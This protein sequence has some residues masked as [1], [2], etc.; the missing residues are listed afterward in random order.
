M[1]QLTLEKFDKLS[2]KLLELA[3]SDLDHLGDFTAMLFGKAV[4]EPFFCPVYSKLCRALS[5]M[6]KEQTMKQPG[7]DK[8]EK[9]ST[10]F[11]SLVL[12][13]CQKQFEKAEEDALRERDADI[14]AKAKVRAY[15][16]LFVSSNLAPLHK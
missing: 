10:V 7:T 15:T 2:Q 11:K 8:E 14:A 3:L 4:D 9:V 1:Q 6:S 13:N 16:P 5:D 12:N